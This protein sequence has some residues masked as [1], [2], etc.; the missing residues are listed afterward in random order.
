MIKFPH[1]FKNW[2]RA[3]LLL[4]IAATFSQAQ[5]VNQRVDPS[6]GGIDRRVQADATGQTADQVAPS[7]GSRSVAGSSA[8]TPTRNAAPAVR[9][10][11][12]GVSSSG[13]QVPGQSVAKPAPS[14]FVPPPN[15]KSAGT[16]EKKN[17][18]KTAVRGVTGKTELSSKFTPSF[19]RTGDTPFAPAARMRS[20]RHS[21]ANASVARKRLVEPPPTSRGAR[22]AKL[23]ISHGDR[24]KR[25]PKNSG[26]R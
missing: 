4:S 21:G 14:P 7:S 20:S 6:I 10:G 1:A 22:S 12:S 17:Q 15:S 16:R 25:R 13:H 2:L 18:P 24:A 9:P 8:W 3:M 19:G 11:F 26:I 5:E 23:R